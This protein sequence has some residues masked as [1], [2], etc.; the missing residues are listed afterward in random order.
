MKTSGQVTEKNIEE[1]PLFF[2]I[3]RPRSGTTLLRSFLDA[4]PNIQIPTECNYIYQLSRKYLKK[5]NWN[6]K[7]ISSFLDDLKRTRFYKVSNFNVEKIEKDL[8]ENKNELTYPLACKII[9]NSF[10]GIFPKNELRTFGDKNP[11]YSLIF[12]YVY[13][14]FQEAKFIHLLRDPRDNH[15]SLSNSRME[16]PYI[17]FTTLR[18]KK[19][20]KQIEKFKQK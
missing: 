2:I 8:R 1:I 11:C 13:P 9:A 16:Y 19:S 18:W 12:G 7:T 10:E 4:H 5:K 15:I 6:D 14:V 20:Y 3:G 17:S